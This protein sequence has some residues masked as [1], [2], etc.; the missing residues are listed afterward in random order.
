MNDPRNLEHAWALE[1]LTAFSIGML[2]EDDT[3]R[4]EEHLAGCDGCRARLA[5]L[6]PVPGADAAH[7]PASLIATW[8]RTARLLGESERGLIASH[9]EA[10]AACRAALAF[11]G[12]E[13]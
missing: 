13:P 12:H 10:C 11:A 1:R 7:L 5:A 2:P 3:L 9:L 4:L 8:E 6:R